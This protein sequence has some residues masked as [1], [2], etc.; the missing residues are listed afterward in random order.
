MAAWCTGLASFSTM[1]GV[2]LLRRGAVIG[3]IAVHRRTS[4]PFSQR[5]ID[6]VTT[7]ADQAV[8]AINN[9]SLFEDVQA[10][11]RELQ[12]TLEYQ[13]ATSDVLSVISRSTFELQPVL[14]AIV[15]TAARLCKAEY[16]F[17]LRYNAGLL[18]MAAGTRLEA[19]FARFI[20]ENPVE[21]SRATVGGRAALERRTVHVPDVLA[22]PEYEWSAGQRIGKYRSVLGVPLLREGEL[23]GVILLLRAASNRFMTSRLNW[24]RPSPTKP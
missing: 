15:E 24:S 5:E 18:Q 14:D 1:L 7:F 11:T 12:E 21:L 17:I 8:I 22:D 10:R 3:V 2:P 20:S 19:D 9:V 4:Q 16:A 6:L 13:T 23:I